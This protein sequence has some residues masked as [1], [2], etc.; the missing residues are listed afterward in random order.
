MIFKKLQEVNP[1]LAS[2]MGDILKTQSIVCFMFKS[3]E[4]LS[5]GS[6][7]NPVLLDEYL[8]TNR[9]KKVTLID[10]N[11][12]SHINL[13]EVVGWQISASREETS[14]DPFDDFK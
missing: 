12:I 5:A 2:E 6:S 13:R 9:R 14:E 8:Y 1:E 7:M 11:E 10:E 3:G 4:Y